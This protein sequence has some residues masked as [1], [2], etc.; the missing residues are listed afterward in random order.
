MELYRGPR[1]ANGKVFESSFFVDNMNYHFKPLSFTDAQL[2]GGDPDSPIEIK[3]I[4]RNQYKMEN[5][6]IC[7]AETTLNKIKAQHMGGKIPLVAPS[8][9]KIA[10]LKVHGCETEKVYSFTEYL[11]AGYEISLI[12]GI[13]FTYSNGNPSN[14]TSIHY[15][16]GEANQYESAI[17]SIGNILSD[18]DSDKKYP[19]Y[20]F[21]AVPK[22]MNSSATEV[23]HCFPL[24]GNASNPE[25][26]GIDSVLQEYKNV[27]NEVKFLGPT[28]FAPLITEARNQVLQCKNPKMY[29][30]LLILTDGEIHDMAE[31]IDEIANCAIMNLPMSIIIVGVG[32]EDFANMV[33][34]D[35]DDVALK[36]GAKDIVQFVKYQEVISRSA[37]NEASENLAALV[38]EEI[39]SQFVRTFAD[40]KMFP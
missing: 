27:L 2:C 1:G 40:K 24:N 15:N 11:S 21:G 28:K 7:Y 22:H 8:G 37:A 12:G 35:G 36:T 6:E 18:Y 34:L 23:S 9:K 26:S 16:E 14:P 10:D 17:K 3:F 30:I 4:N 32:D 39:P 19:F 5:S 31:T 13:D 20:G 38:L 29:H 25:I 33:R